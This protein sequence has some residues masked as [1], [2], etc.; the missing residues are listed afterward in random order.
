VNVTLG[1]DDID[2]PAG[3]CTTHFASLLVEQLEPVVE[4][5]ADYPHLI[6]LNPN[7]P[8]RTR[9]NGCVALR[10]SAD[11]RETDEL[12]PKIENR[13]KEYSDLDYPNTNPGVT[14][15]KG[16][17]PDSIRTFSHTTVWRVV[18]IT[19]AQRLIS[20]H[21]IEHREFGN[22]R[23]LVGALAA[24]GHGLEGDHTYEFLAY[25]SAVNKGQRRGVLKESVMAMD[26]LMGEDTFSNIDNTSDK[27]LIEPQGP[28]PVLY[29]IRGES[30]NAVARAASMVKSI[31]KSERHMIFRTNQGTGEHLSH[32]VPISMLRPY[33]SAS[34]NCEVVTK[35]KII[36]G[37]HV[38]LRVSDTG[39]Q[40][41][42]AAYEPTGDFRWTV[43]RLIG[44]DRIALHVGVRPKSRTHG[45]T[46]NIEGMEIVRL[47]DDIRYSNPICRRCGHRMKSAGMNKGFR[48]VNC[49][50]KDADAKKTVSYRPRGIKIGLYL[51]RP[52]A[53]RHL[54]RPT[55]RI[56]RVNLTPY[57]LIANWHA[58]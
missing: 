49:G 30:P 35:P 3:G 37:G 9:G 38:I 52:S 29:G 50:T 7:I 36:E 25:R 34:V 28:D 47:A 51:P 33:M 23:G 54:T 55:S 6:R 17:V 5:W 31:Q 58:P 4:K 19:L 16:Q 56:S 10:F 43:T 45:M 42:C 8:F 41:D 22:G 27:I 1:M 11:S 40:I 24:L 12:L 13:I 15:I 32:T 18:P 53:Q 39:A 21:V 46:L 44:G 14:L 57:G 20:N 2:S 48:C 26:Q